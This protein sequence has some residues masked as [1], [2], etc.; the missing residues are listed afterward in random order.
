MARCRIVISQRKTKWSFFLGKTC[1]Y[2]SWE[3]IWLTRCIIHR[4]RIWFV[5]I[6]THFVSKFELGFIEFVLTWK[7]RISFFLI[8]RTFYWLVA[9]F[10]CQWPLAFNRR[11]ITFIIFKLRNFVSV[12]TWIYI[13]FFN[14]NLKQSF[15]IISYAAS[16]YNL[17]IFIIIVHILHTW[18]TML[19][20]NWPNFRSRIFR[21]VYFNFIFILISRNQK[22][23][24]FI[25]HYF[26]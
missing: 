8:K 22:I 11:F 17:L 4:T 26:I 20:F 24:S 10:L 6:F 9:L 25:F 19:I 5:F 14:W 16:S 18:H 12:W 23:L 1:F 7:N 21:K 13:W 3:T 15:L 2:V